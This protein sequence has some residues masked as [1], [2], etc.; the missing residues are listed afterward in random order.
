MDNKIPYLDFLFSPE[1]GSYFGG[2]GTNP[3]SWLSKCSAKVLL[4]PGWVRVHQ[5]P[6]LLRKSHKRPTVL[7]VSRNVFVISLAYTSTSTE[8][9]S[10]LSS[11]VLILF[12][13]SNSQHKEVS[14]LYPQNRLLPVRWYSGCPG[15]S[16]VTWRRRCRTSRIRHCWCSS[17]RS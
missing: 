3:L 11:V 12:M 9:C 17:H 1:G 4:S 14:I 5:S 16:K 2:G 6:R 7:M 10:T 15:V 8:S 13:C